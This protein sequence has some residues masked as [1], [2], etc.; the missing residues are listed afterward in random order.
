MPRRDGTGPN[1]MGS[2]TGRG[3]GMCTGVNAPGL[4][5]GYG[6]GYGRRGGMRARNGY[7]YGPGFRGGRGG[8]GGGGGWWG[9]TPDYAAVYPDARES[10][11]ERAAFLE[12]ELASVKRRMEELNGDDAE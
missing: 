1:G 9:G 7:G 6:A 3:L 8:W 5:R 2:Q 4:N 12:A 11:E 10:L